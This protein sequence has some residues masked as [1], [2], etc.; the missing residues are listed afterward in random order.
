MRKYWLGVVLLCAASAT[1]AVYK[2]VD[3]N[4]VTQYSGIPPAD[5]EAHEVQMLPAAAEAAAPEVPAAASPQAAPAAT[6]EDEEAAAKR[7]QIERARVAQTRTIQCAQ[8]R[9]NLRALRRGGPVYEINKAGE[10]VLLT[11][12]ERAAALE[13]A[14]K[15]EQKYC[16]AA[17]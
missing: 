10:Q 9:E 14:Q 2:W 1:A 6:P 4:G 15:M 3:A 12:D 7:E 8:Y 16:T 5:R 13:V 17:P 11:D